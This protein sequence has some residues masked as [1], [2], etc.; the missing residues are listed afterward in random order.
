MELKE[1]QEMEALVDNKFLEEKL[2]VSRRTIERWRKEGMPH[3]NLRG[4]LR[5]NFTEVMNW[6]EESK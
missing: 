2:N 1:L 6:L 5:Y 4:T 3:K